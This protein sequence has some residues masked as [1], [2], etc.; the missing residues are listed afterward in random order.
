MY[1]G[2]RTVH[3]GRVLVCLPGGVAGEHGGLFVRGGRAPV[4]GAGFEM[5]VRRSLMRPRGPSQ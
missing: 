3:G 1:R 4:C 2:F 5:P